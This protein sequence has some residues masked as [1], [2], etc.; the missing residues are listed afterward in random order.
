MWRTRSEPPVA[1]CRYRGASLRPIRASD[2]PEA[3]GMTENVQT[4]PIEIMRTFVE[5]HR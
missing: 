4:D 1:G 5:R 2:D 3:A